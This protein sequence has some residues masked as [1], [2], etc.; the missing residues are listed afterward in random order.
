[1]GPQDVVDDLRRRACSPQWLGFVRAMGEEFAGELD[2]REMLDLLARIGLR[3]GRDR[4]LGACATLAELEQAANRQ[5]Q[6]IGWGRCSF[7]EEPGR[8][9][10]VHL[11][12]PINVALEGDWADGFLQGVYQAW[13]EQQGLLAGLAVKAVPPQSR[14]MRRFVLARGA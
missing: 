6:A 7:E 5:W 8:V 13:F 3:F 14:D 9:G 12:P 4:V 11:A 10:I 1:M 2:E